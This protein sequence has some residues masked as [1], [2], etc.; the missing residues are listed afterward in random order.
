VLSR[1]DDAAVPGDALAPAAAAAA[2]DDVDRRRHTT[3]AATVTKITTNN[4]ITPATIGST[5]TPSLKLD[6]KPA[7]ASPAR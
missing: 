7:E 4:A 5:E 3:S 1:A 2:L 6:P